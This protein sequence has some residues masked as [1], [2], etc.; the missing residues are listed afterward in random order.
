MQV[1]EIILDQSSKETTQHGTFEFPL[2]IYTTQISKNILG[3]IPWHW[4]EELQFCVITEGAVEIQINGDTVVLTKGEGIFIN[5]GQMHQAN[6]YNKTNGAYICIDFHPN[7]ISGHTGSI[8]FSK[9]VAPYIE[10]HLS[11]FIIL[12]PNQPWEASVIQRLLDIETTHRRGE[13]DY[14]LHIHILLLQIWQTLLNNGFTMASQNATRS[15]DPRIK[16]MIEYINDHYAEPFRLDDL[17]AAVNLSK[18][19]CCR[20]F[21]KH[22]KRTVFDYLLDH[23]LIA[24]TRQLLT[25]DASITQIAYDCGFGSASYFIEKFKAKSGLPPMVYRRQNTPAHIRPIQIE[26]LPFRK[27]ENP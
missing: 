15:W 19:A 14:E 22:V 21:K 26:P 3:S 25:T 11:P 23:R 10:H 13:Q 2:A 5:V 17:A 27:G 4:H 8:L 12:K 24:S 20:T 7:L 9:Y 1:Y 16:I 6:N 18:S